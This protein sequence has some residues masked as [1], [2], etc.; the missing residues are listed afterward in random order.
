MPYWGFDCPVQI[1][2]DT[3]VMISVKK[4]TMFSEIDYLQQPSA[5]LVMMESARMSG[6]GI[7]SIKKIM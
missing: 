2:E 6:K 7:E 3:A 4:W 1:P 5:S